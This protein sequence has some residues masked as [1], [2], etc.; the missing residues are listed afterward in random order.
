MDTLPED[1]QNNIYK[2][3]HQM[4]LM[5][6]MSELISESLLSDES[7][8]LESSSKHPARLEKIINKLS[9]MALCQLV[10]MARRFLLTI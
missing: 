8:V 7:S 9:K 2:M 10:F 5:D 4:R 3:A 6:V 1:I